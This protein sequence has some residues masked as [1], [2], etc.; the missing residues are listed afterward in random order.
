MALYKGSNKIAGETQKEIDEDISNFSINFT[1]NSDTNSTFTSL[2]EKIASGAQLSKLISNIKACLAS[3]GNYA[4][5]IA[6]KQNYLENLVDLAVDAGTFT[7]T[8]NGTGCWLLISSHPFANRG[9]YIAS[10]YPDGT[11]SAI[12]TI[13][14]DPVLTISFSGATMTIKSTGNCRVHAVRVGD[15]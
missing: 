7:H 14:N 6:V 15:L 2:Y 8:F 9:F 11:G 12:S 4:N 5:S 10:V 1:E 13:L 3:V